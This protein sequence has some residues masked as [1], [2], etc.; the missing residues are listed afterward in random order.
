MSFSLCL[1]PLGSFRCSVVCSLHPLPSS[2]MFIA[3][4]FS[5]LFSVLFRYFSTENISIGLLVLG[6]GRD[7]T[8]RG[9]WG[10]AP[11]FGLGLSIFLV[12]SSFYLLKQCLLLNLELTYLASIS[13]S[14][15][16]GF[17]LYPARAW[18]IR[19]LL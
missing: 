2:I 14:L 12:F 1:H 8:G 7:V 5:S 4:L 3:V 17:C 18:T 6:L 19:S 9:N 15:T 10:R 13:S 11:I 16:S